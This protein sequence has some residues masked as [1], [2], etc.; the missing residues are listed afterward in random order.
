M[1]A[2]VEFISEEKSGIIPENCKSL[3]KFI[4]FRFYTTGGTAGRWVLGE[5]FGKEEVTETYILMNV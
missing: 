5:V 1:C 4:L 2:A 3:S